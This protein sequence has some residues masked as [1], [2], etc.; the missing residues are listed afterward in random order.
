MRKHSEC[1]EWGTSLKA[2][3]TSAATT[4]LAATTP[5]SVLHA[6]AWGWRISL[7][8]A[9]AL[10]LTATLATH[11]LWLIVP[12]PSD[13]DIFIRVARDWAAGATLYVDTYDIKLPTVYGLVRLLDSSNP[14]LTWYLA[15]TVYMTIAA[16]ALFAAMRR[17]APIAAFVPPMLMIAWTGTMGTGQQTEAVALALDVTA[18]SLCAIAARTGRWWLGSVAGAC[19]ALMVSFRPPTLLH[20]VAYAPVLWVAYRSQGPRSRRGRQPPFSSAQLRSSLQSWRTR[21]STAIGR[22]SSIECGA[23]W[24]TRRCRAYRWDDR[25]GRLPSGCELC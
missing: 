19:V 4:E 5:L 21:W 13:L 2:S 17:A 20:L 12:L 1:E 11:F 16:T 24:S 8:A 9:V 23:M 25:S 10:F 22:R 18:L 6:P 7:P 14:A 3:G 15:E